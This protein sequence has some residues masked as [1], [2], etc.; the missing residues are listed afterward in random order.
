MIQYSLD[1]VTLVFDDNHRLYSLR[2]LVV[3]AVKHLNILLDGQI[4]RIGC[5]TTKLHE[6]KRTLQGMIL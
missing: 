6:K 4:L 1:V 3:T 5:G 2:S